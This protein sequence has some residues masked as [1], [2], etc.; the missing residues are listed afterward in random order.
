[1]RLY[2]VEI[3]DSNFNFKSSHPISDRGKYEYDYISISVNKVSVPVSS[4]IRTEQR[5]SH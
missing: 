4:T 2:N 5:T 3:F 1:M